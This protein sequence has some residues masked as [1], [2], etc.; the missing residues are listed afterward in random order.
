MY[1]VGDK[2]LYPMHGAGLIEAIEECVVMGKS[3][4]YYTM[5][6][7]LGDMKVMIPYDG[8]NNAGLRDIVDE[9]TA[10]EVIEFMAEAIKEDAV[11]WNRRYRENSEKIKSGNI[12]HVAEVVKSLMLRD[13]EKGLSTGERKMLSDSRH[14]LISEL[15]LAK[16]MEKEEISAILEEKVFDLT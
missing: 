12:F 1:K 9:K 5:H 8:E 10:D 11:S 2:V 6:M 4:K 14:I 16:N 13:K 3:H 7:P 15:V